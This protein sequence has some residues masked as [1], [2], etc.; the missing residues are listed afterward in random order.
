MPDCSTKTKKTAVQIWEE[1]WK[2]IKSESEYAS[3]ARPNSPLNIYVAGMPR[4]IM[5]DWK[6]SLALIQMQSANDSQD[7]V[8]ATCA[9]RHNFLQ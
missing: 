3:K 8:S 6:Q 9:I 5:I 2:T 4:T 1:E 7:N